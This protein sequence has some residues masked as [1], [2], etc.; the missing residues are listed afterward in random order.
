MLSLWFKT[1]NYIQ[2]HS[3]WSSI[4]RLWVKGERAHVVH[5]SKIAGLKKKKK[6]QM[7]TVP[8]WKAAWHVPTKVPLP[9]SRMWTFC[10]WFNLFSSLYSPTCTLLPHPIPSFFLC[11]QQDLHSKLEALGKVES[12]SPLTLTIQLVKEQ[13]PTFEA[14]DIATYEQKLQQWHLE[15]VHL[16]QR[17]Q[18]QREKA[19]QE[20]EA[21]R[22]AKASA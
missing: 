1:R 2:N 20:H 11:F 6:K 21:Q 22:A 4:Y 13:L 3:I 14:E 8:R 10:K 15:R 17:E 9:V 7:L 18:E 19:K 5:L 16:I 12:E